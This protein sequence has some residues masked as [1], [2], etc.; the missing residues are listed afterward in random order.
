MLARYNSVV[1]HERKYDSSPCSKIRCQQPVCVHVFLILDKCIAPVTLNIWFFREARL[2]RV[3][4]FPKTNITP[5]KTWILTHT[6]VR[7]SNLLLHCFQFGYWNQC[8]SQ[9]PRGLRR[10][11]T[12]ARLVGLRFG[13]PPGAWMC[14][15]LVIVVCCQVEVSASGWSL[16]QRIP[17]ECC[18]SECDRGASIMRRPWPTRGCCARGGRNIA[19]SSLSI[20]TFR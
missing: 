10:G 6:A 2:S 14:L 18:V 9:W 12:A 19:I 20:T 4:S 16:I 7:T 5:H 15:S 8:Q 13:I 3:V 17:T 11:S 1:T